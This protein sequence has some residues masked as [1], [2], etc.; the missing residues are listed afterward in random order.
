[1][2]RTFNLYINNFGDDELREN[3]PIYICDYP[4]GQAGVDIAI[5]QAKEILSELRFDD[6]TQINNLISQG[7]I[8]LTEIVPIAI[9]Y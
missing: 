3:F 4:E 1:M 7:D 6:D 9:R 2:S 5:E 8:T